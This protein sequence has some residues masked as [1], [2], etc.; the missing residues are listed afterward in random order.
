LIFFVF[1]QP[2]STALV[3]SKRVGSHS[4]SDVLQQSQQGLYIMSLGQR[5]YY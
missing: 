4:L 1:L 2:I 5:T 3:I